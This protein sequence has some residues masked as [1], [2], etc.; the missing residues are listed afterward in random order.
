MKWLKIVSIIHCRK[1]LSKSR[2]TDRHGARLDNGL[3][4]KTGKSTACDSR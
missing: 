4:K 2:L 3:Q 1:T